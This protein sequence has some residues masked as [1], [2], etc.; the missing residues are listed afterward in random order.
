MEYLLFCSHVGRPLGTGTVLVVHCE[1]SVIGDMLHA[2]L[3]PSSRWD[4]LLESPLPVYSSSNS[5]SDPAGDGKEKFYPAPDSATLNISPNTL[6]TS[7]LLQHIT[8]P[9]NLPYSHGLIK[10]LYNLNCHLKRTQLHCIQLHP[11]LDVILKDSQSNNITPR[12]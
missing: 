5:K 8:K 11:A 12:P 2:A 9:N 10:N 1:A 3:V 7:A 6:R 4:G